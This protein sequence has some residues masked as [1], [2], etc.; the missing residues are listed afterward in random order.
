LDWKPYEREIE[1][2]FRSEYPSAHITKNAKRLGRFSKVERQIDVLIEQLVCDLPFHIAVDAKFRGIKIDVKDVEEFLG[3]V[4][5]V[6]AHKAIMIAPEGYTDAA[7]QRASA[8]DADVILDVLN[9]SELQRYQGFGAFPF[10]GQHAVAL[11]APFG[12]VVD[13][14]QGRGALAWLYQQGLT[15]DE[16][17]RAGEFMYVT[18]GKMR[19]GITSIESISKFQED[20]LR[21]NSHVISMAYME[22]VPRK[23]AKTAIRSVVYDAK[24]R[25]GLL[26]ETEYTGFVEFDGFVL[27]CVLF[28]RND[29][30]EK[31]LSKLR[32]VLRKVLP[33]HVRYGNIDSKP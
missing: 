29:L 22:G 25:P 4:R 7:T 5:D 32:F 16:A 20:Y 23:D 31:N 33:I 12:W 1:T 19:D 9:F 3:M 21:K 26:D 27:M 17:T 8:D 13:A 14:T 30:T 28:T 11:P 18:I 2:Y 24:T 6:C 15:L 10:A